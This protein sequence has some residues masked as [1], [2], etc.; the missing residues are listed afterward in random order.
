MKVIECM[1][2][3]YARLIRTGLREYAAV[4]EAYREPVR[5]YIETGATNG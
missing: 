1:V 2:R 3:V 5:K 4:P